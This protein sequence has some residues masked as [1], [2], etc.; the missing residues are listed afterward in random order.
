M[1]IDSSYIEKAAVFIESFSENYHH[2]KELDF[3]VLMPEEDI[4]SFN[5]LLSLV[6]V[7]QRINLRGRA[8][9]SSKYKWIEKATVKDPR[10]SKVVWYRL[11]L[12]SALKEY[13]KVIYF[14]PDMLVVDNVQPILDHPLHN[15]VMAVYDVTGVQYQYAKGRGETAWFT[16]GVLILNLD[17]WRENKIERTLVADLEK[18]GADELTDEHLFNKYLKDYWHPLPITFNFY[19]YDSDAHGVPNWDSSYLPAFYKHAIVHHFVGPVKPWNYE[20]FDDKAD[21]SRLGAEWRRRFKEIQ[22]R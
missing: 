19:A 2:Y 21:P 17:W 8:I 10:Y 18:N 6:R 12:G 1:T 16:T 15:N 5:Q 20:N 13:N 14:E 3:V 4:S 9:Q 22:S 11:I 7:N